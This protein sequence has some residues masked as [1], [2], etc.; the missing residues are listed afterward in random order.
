ME[1]RLYKEAMDSVY[2]A[3][4]LRFEAKAVEFMEMTDI[5]RKTELSNMFAYLEGLKALEI[6]NTSPLNAIRHEID[7]IEKNILEF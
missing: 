5:P 3:H 6:S 2:N 1:K 4:I 7:R